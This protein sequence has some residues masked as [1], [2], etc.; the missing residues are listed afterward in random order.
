VFAKE[1]RKIIT[2]IFTI[3]GIVSFL[4]F[5][6]APMLTSI[7]NP[8]QANPAVTPGAGAASASQLEEQA[9]GYELVLQRE[10]DNQT[11][12]RGLLDIR[13]QQGN[14]QEA[15]KPLEKLAQLN[16]EQ[17]EYTVLLAQAKQRLGDREGAAQAYRNVLASHPGDINALQ[18]LVGLLLEQKRPQA[19]I[20]LLQDTL[21][22]ADE[23][24]RVQA[25]SVNVTSVQ[26]LLGQV[27]VG[28]GRYDEAIAV[29]DQAIQSDKHD[30]RPVFAKAV[31][32]QRQGK[33]EAAQ[34]LFASA[35]ELAPAQYKDQINQVAKAP[36]TP[37]PGANG[38]SAAPSTP[39]NNS[40]APAPGEP[41]PAAAGQTQTAP[42]P[43]APKAS[44]DSG[45]N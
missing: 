36:P 16:P 44:P 12:L 1:N 10:A 38:T 34:A 40:S 15:I 45:T 7:F 21:K 3:A 43:V 30:F 20:G 18:G 26:I 11:A 23:A 13:L 19:A 27:Y 17:T 2:W 42:I 37:A 41:S 33:R 31:V 28:E 29:L 5:A 14:I 9:K 4:G 22:T 32:L 8:P 24:N 25:G 6:I 39:T 35:A